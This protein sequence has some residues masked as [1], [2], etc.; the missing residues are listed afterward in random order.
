[1]KIVNNQ[2]FSNFW[3]GLVKDF[4]VYPRPKVIL[5]TLDPIKLQIIV[6]FDQMMLNQSITDF[7]INLDVAGPNSPYSVTYKATFLNDKF[8]IDFSMTP[9]FLGGVGEMVLLQ[10]LTVTK[11]KSDRLIPMLSPAVFNFQ[12]GVLAA[13]ESSQ[14]GSSSASYMFIVT[15]LISLGI[16]LV[17]GGSMELMWSLANTLQMLYYFGMLDLNF[18]SD[19]NAVYDFLK[20]SNFDNPATD[21]IKQQSIVLIQFANSPVNTN[22][23]SIGFGSTDILANCLSKLFIVALLISA[24]VLFGVIAYKWKDSNSRL[25]KFIKNQDKK[26]RYESIS[27]FVL[28][29]TLNFA[30]ASLINLIYW[31]RSNAQDIIGMI[32]AC[33]TLIGLLYFLIYLFIYPVMYFESIKNEPEKHVRHEIVFSQFKQN[34]LKSMHYFAYF[35]L[36]RLLFSLVIVAMP[37]FAIKQWILIMLLCLWIFIYQIIIRPYNSLLNNFIWTFNEGILFVYSWLMYIFL[38]SSDPDRLKISGY[39]WIALIIAFFMINWVII[40]PVMIYGLWVNM[41]KLFMKVWIK[42]FGKGKVSNQS[43]KFFNLF[44]SIILSKSILLFK[45]LIL[46]KN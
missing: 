6:E 43:S 22:F 4:T 42:L 3:E 10:L 27:R 26:L 45:S 18:P 29:L 39:V 38:D 41:K 44:L 5:S 13:S 36:R 24:A 11:F 23:G 12:V 25:I 40:S 33:L 7:D 1:M 20:Y 31:E 2:Y 15:M 16:S 28:E 30:V 8:I 46:K 14:S 34:K 35:V 32:V 37:K 21:F 17:T 9:S 19:L